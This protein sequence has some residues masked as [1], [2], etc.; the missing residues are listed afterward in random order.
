MTSTKHLIDDIANILDHLPD[1]MSKPLTA[2]NYQEK[3]AAYGV[4]AADMAKDQPPIEG[5]ETHK[6][7]A[8]NAQD[9]FEV[10]VFL[11][12]ANEAAATK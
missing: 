6:L 10:P 3:R 5:I 8:K 12:L 1:L 4:I 7:I 2:E 11:H 9:G